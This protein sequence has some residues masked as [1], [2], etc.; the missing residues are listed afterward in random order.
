MTKKIIYSAVGVILLVCAFFVGKSFGTADQF[1]GATSTTGATNTTAKLYSIAMAPA[2]DSAST[3]SLYNGDSV[4][5]GIIQSVAFCTGV[6]TSKTYL[7]GT[8]LASWTLQM[9]TSTASVDAKANTNYASNLTLA[10]SSAWVEVASTT[11]A[12][13]GATGLV[14][15]TGT[16][17]NITFNATNTAACTVG[18]S[19]VS[20]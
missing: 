20:L 13:L 6:G 15:P 11:Y 16:Y 3:T 17:L 9:S 19:A 10:T 18:V 5:R 1:A 12:V 7:T 8:G 4:D 14:W 2:T